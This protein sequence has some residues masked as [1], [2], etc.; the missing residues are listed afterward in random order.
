MAQV[1]IQL[2]LGLKLYT[3]DSSVFLLVDISLY[4]GSVEKKKT[5]GNILDNQ[6]CNVPEFQTISFECLS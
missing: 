5:N 1:C 6:G 2:F 4:K 3:D